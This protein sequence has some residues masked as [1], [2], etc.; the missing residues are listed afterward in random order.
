MFKD[1]LHVLNT[2]RPI[3]DKIDKDLYELRV[4]FAWNNVRVLYAY[5]FKDYIVLLH[6]LVK[7]TDKIPENDKDKARM[8]MF[9]F[10]IRC[11]EGKIKLTKNVDFNGDGIIDPLQGEGKGT[12][13][14]KTYLDETDMRI[15]D[16]KLDLSSVFINLG[17]KL[18]W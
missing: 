3:I 4:E 1:D 8:R 17:L 6:G 13:L 5:M 14:K 16:L 10:Q 12:T 9:D 7:K 18:R 11:N 15:D 2:G